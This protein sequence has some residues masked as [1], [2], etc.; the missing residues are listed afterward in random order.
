MTQ[1]SNHVANNDF[2]HDCGEKYLFKEM[3][4][5]PTDWFFAFEFK[6]V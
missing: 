6:L 3:A 5:F 2:Q 4:I 1:A